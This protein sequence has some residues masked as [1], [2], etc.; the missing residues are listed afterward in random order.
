MAKQ[1]Q[2]NASDLID[3]IVDLVDACEYDYEGCDFGPAYGMATA[4]RD[5]ALKRAKKVIRGREYT[6]GSIE[7]AKHFLSKADEFRAN[8]DAVFKMEHPQGYRERLPRE[9]QSGWHDI[10]S[11]Q[12]WATML[13]DSLTESTVKKDPYFLG[14]F[15]FRLV[16]V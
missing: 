11:M 10:Y 16:S 12:C 7:H 4:R 6:D 1:T 14:V 3:L 2:L 13:L 9:L 15:C 8:L 5:D